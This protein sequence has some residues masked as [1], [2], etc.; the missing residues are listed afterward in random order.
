MDPF[1]ESFTQ[2]TLSV[3]DLVHVT[4]SAL[5]NGEPIC[6]KV[7]GMVFWIKFDALNQEFVGRLDNA[8]SDKYSATEWTRIAGYTA[9]DST[10]GKDSGPASGG[11]GSSAPEPDRLLSAGGGNGAGV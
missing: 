4:F 11:G 9:L 1:K 5:V 10:T 8:N 3:D 6:V 2:G 7:L